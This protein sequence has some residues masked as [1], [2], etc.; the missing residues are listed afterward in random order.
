M[1]N[2]NNIFI[3]NIPHNIS[4]DVYMKKNNNKKLVLFCHGFKGFKDWGAWN[5]VAEAFAAAGFIFVKFNFSHNGIGLENFQNFTRLDLFA[6]NN[7]SK[8]LADVQ[9]VLNWI[10]ND[11]F[12]QDKTVEEINIIG[13]SRGGG[14]ALVSALETK[15]ICKVATWASIA[16]FDRFG[17][18]ENI[19]NWKKEGAKNFY[20][21][22]TKQD[23]KIDFQF[24]EDYLNCQ[25]RLNI[26]KT[27][28]NLDKPLLVGHGKKD[29]AVG[30]SHAQRIKNWQDNA[31]LFLLDDANHVFGAKHP[32]SVNVLPTDLEMLVKKT[33]DFFD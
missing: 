7:Y 16:N 4:A 24:Y 25:E 26:E 11:G 8:E 28:Q 15:E 1:K 21:S 14:I 10:K 19:S 9:T 31:E 17:N 13:H 30:F 33:L 23:M 20:N 6:Q 22:R 2:Y 18:E 5:L 12:W 32:Y 3:K 27:C 29:D